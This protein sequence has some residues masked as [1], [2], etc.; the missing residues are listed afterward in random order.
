[1]GNIKFRKGI[2][3]FTT[4]IQLNGQDPFLG[5]KLTWAS[6]LEILKGVEKNDDPVR[7]RSR[8]KIQIIR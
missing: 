6:R 8:V 2:K 5:G 7:W 3:N 4:I 1:M